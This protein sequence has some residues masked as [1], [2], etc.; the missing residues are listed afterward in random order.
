MKR[1]VLLLLIMLAP[2]FAA[3]QGKIVLKGRVIDSMTK[4]G[5]DMATVL[6]YE[7]KVKAY[8]FEDGTYIIGVPSP[9]KYTL[10]VRANGMQTHQETIEVKADMERNVV[11]KPASVQGG[12]LTI[13]GERDIQKISR[14]TMTLKQLKEVPASFGDSINALTSLPNVM[15]TDGL[16]GPLVIRGASPES[17]GYF[18]DSIPLYN[19]MHF[20]GIHSVI[21]NNLMHE[22]DLYASS[23]PSTFGNATGAII[24]INTLDEVKEFGGYADMGLISSAALVKKPITET[25]LDEN[26]AEKK[27]NKGYVIVSGRLGYISVF[28]RAF[29]A[30]YELFGKDIPAQLP[31]YGDYQ[32]KVKYALTDRT[33]LTF[34]AFGSYDYIDL[35]LPESALSPGDDPIWAKAT[36]LENTYAHGQGLTLKYTPSD[37]FTNSTL[38]YSSMMVTTTE[39]TIPGSNQTALR[40]G[41]KIDNMPIIS[42]LKNDF[43]VDLIKDHFQV[44]GSAEY[45]FY[46]FR[47]SGQTGEPNENYDPS[48]GFDPSKDQFD[49][50]YIDDSYINHTVGGYL[51]SKITLGWLEMIPGCRVDYLARVNEAAVQPRGMAALKFP[52]G[53]TLSVAGGKY[54]YFPQVNPMFFKTAPQAASADY[55]GA[56]NAY[57][58]SA[59]I[60]Q[61]IGDFSVKVEGFRNI[62]PNELQEE[63]WNDDGTERSYRDCARLET[64]GGEIMLKLDQRENENGPYGWIS[65]TYD[66]ARFRTGARNNDPENYD[67]WVND[68]YEMEHILKAVVGYVHNRHALGLRFQYN[69]ARPYTPIVDGELTPGYYNPNGPTHERWSPVYGDYN[70][71]RLGAQHRLDVRYTYKQNYEWGYFS[72][73]LEVINATNYI[74]DEVV[75]DYRYDKDDPR[76]G[77]NPR[78]VKDTDMIAFLPNFGIEIKF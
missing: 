10:M 24:N 26:G 46:F 57:H 51:E 69:T 29:E 15:R 14:H 17:N 71:K 9:G 11:M 18:I 32:L 54:S 67:T 47:V 21:N 74:A 25:Y 8:T 62:F 5:I 34:L 52:S 20:G 30:A 13:T 42:G 36:Y 61:K 2:G 22:V 27:R 41:I 3:A 65:Y 43:K 49:L 77:K 12:T 60:E 64:Q 39:M 56:I 19:P 58:S 68:D 6:I 63:T 48:Q 31:Y 38:L 44:R 28:F 1:I 73:Y 55:I 76:K 33:S 53:T 78:T 40:E 16:F 72:W 4:K 37:V 75:W 45:G 66:Q 59:G 35:T 70:S 7:A 23:F 50:V